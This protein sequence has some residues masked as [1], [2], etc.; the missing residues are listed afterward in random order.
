LR[1]NIIPGDACRG[2]SALP[3]GRGTV[4]LPQWMQRCASSAICDPQWWQNIASI[5]Q[6]GPARRAVFPFRTRR[7]HRRAGADYA[8]TRRFVHDATETRMRTILDPDRDPALRLELTRA[9]LPV[10]RAAL[11]RASFIDTRPEMQAA[12]FDLVERLLSQIPE[13]PPA[14]GRK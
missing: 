11:E 12:V 4:A 2:A 1:Q 7:Y 10:F 5:S 14:A 3:S 13:E 6:R 9:E 8:A